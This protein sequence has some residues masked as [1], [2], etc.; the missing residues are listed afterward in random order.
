MGYASY[1]IVR[2][3]SGSDRKVA[4]GLYASQL[5]LNWAWTP[6]FFGQHKLGLACAEIGLMWLNIAACA[7]KFYPINTTAA[8]SGMGQFGHLPKLQH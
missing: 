2:D 8:L 4:L 5:A 7:W 1:L 3:G 6:I